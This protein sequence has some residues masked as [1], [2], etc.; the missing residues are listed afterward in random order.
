MARF[1]DASLDMGIDV[2]SA[3]STFLVMGSPPE[4]ESEYMGVLS[5]G[6]VDNGGDGSLAHQ[7]SENVAITGGTIS[8]VTLINVTVDG[9]WF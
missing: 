8:N 2:S 1:I 5:F 6:D 7:D 3:H 4:D 9:G